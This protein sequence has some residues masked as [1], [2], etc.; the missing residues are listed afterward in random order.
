MK[1]CYLIDGFPVELQL[2]GGNITAYMCA[3][4]YTDFKTKLS[5][6]PNK[7]EIYERRRLQMA[8][9]IGEQSAF[10]EYMLDELKGNVPDY[11]KFDPFVLDEL[12][13]L[14]ENRT[15]RFA[16]SIIPICELSNFSFKENCL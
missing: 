13:Q 1:L 14:E 15:L 8:I 16:E 7:D 4:G 12:P 11:S 6:S 9:Q 5:L 2:L 10:R 3:K